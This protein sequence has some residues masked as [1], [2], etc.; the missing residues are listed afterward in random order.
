M[1]FCL[2]VFNSYLHNYTFLYF[3]SRRKYLERKPLTDSAAI[4]LLQIICTIDVDKTE[5]KY[6]TLSI[7]QLPLKPLLAS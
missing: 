4:S 3:F 5:P 2:L 6:K 1:I 7:Q